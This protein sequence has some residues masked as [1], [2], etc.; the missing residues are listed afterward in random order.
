MTDYYAEGTGRVPCDAD[1]VPLP[2]GPA[3]LC[4]ACKGSGVEGYKPCPNCHGSGVGEYGQFDPSPLG[5]PVLGTRDDDWP[6]DGE[7][8]DFRLW[9]AL[10]DVKRRYPLTDAMQDF[11]DRYERGER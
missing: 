2:Q 6:S 10:T 1:G 5:Q 8:D 11:L 3:P 4:F 7:R 9:E